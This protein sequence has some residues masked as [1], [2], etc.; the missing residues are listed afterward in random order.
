ME[1]RRKLVWELATFHLQP[2]KD[3][4]WESLCG[5]TFMDAY[6]CQPTEYPIIEALVG[7]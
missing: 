5:R 1:T 2:I 6:V 7:S 4:Q 3:Y